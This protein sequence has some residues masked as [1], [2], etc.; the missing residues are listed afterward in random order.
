MG[1]RASWSGAGPIARLESSFEVPIS[2]QTNDK[3]VRAVVLV[4]AF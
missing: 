4:V 3:H 1:R 2:M